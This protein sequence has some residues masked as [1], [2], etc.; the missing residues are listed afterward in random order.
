MHARDDPKLPGDS[1]EVPIS[2]WNARQ[3]N[4]RCEIFSP[5]DK[6]KLAKKIGSQQRTHRKVG[7]SRPHPTPRRFLE[8]GK[9]SKL[10]FTSDCPTLV[11][12]LHVFLA[13]V[14][15]SHLN[16]STHISNM[17][18]QL[19]WVTKLCLFTLLGWGYTKYG[20]Y[21]HQ[22]Y[23]PCSTLIVNYPCKCHP[24]YM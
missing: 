21:C 24:H 20:I 14:W 11:T 1:G 22:S 7:S 16:I 2:K 12:Y 17:N 10:K 6:E 4:S 9:A 19:R 3:F 23:L 13:C 18:A 8:Q 5:L 15:N